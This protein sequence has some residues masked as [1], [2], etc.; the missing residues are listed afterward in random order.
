MSAQVGNQK[1]IEPLLSDTSSTCSSESVAEC[2]A[3]GHPP[4]IPRIFIQDE[5]EC[6]IICD[7]ASDS[8]NQTANGGQ[9]HRYMTKFATAS[10]ESSLYDINDCNNNADGASG[11][12]ETKT[13]RSS[14]GQSEVFHE[15]KSNFRNSA[16]E[17]IPEGENHLGKSSRANMRKYSLPPK[18]IIGD[19]DGNLKGATSEDFDIIRQRHR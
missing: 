1:E 18:F 14:A 7:D 17:V 8:E 19:M 3:N 12:V 13:R 4:V 11:Q 16:T 2:L 10:R 9:N 6:R 15:A 5:N